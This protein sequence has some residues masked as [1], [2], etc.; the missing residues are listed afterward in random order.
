M[1]ITHNLKV[2]ILE[3]VTNEKGCMLF[4]EKLREV[5]YVEPPVLEVRPG[6]YTRCLIR[7]TKRETLDNS[8]KSAKLKFSY[9]FAEETNKYNQDL[10]SKHPH[11]P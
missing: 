1:A 3:R 7:T 5:L 10:C 8:T 6:L 4:K 2:V 9:K 11:M